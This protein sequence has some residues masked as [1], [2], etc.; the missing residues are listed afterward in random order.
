MPRLFAGTLE[1][2]ED[3]V[4][5]DGDEPA[6]LKGKDKWNSNDVVVVKKCFIPMETL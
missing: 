2:A 4:G 6:T 1:W 3:G 5:N